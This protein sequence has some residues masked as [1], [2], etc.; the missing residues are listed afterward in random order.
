M[1]NKSITARDEKVKVLGVYDDV[2]HLR[3]NSILCIGHVVKE[4][5]NLLSGQNHANYMNK[6]DIVIL[7]N[8]S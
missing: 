8:S 5:D 6:R 3:A 4:G 2:G 7:V 1:E